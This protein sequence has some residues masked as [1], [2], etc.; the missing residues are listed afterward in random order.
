MEETVSPVKERQFATG[1]LTATATARRGS[2]GEIF[3]RI[4]CAVYRFH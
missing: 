1:L 3:M 2:Y 4:I